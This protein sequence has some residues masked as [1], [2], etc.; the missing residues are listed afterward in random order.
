MV[1]VSDTGI[2]IDKDNVGKLFSKFSQLEAGMKKAGN[3]GS[4]L[5]LFIAKGIVE[6]SGGK[7]WVDSA[8]VG[9]GSTFYFTV[10][11]AANEGRISPAV[12]SEKKTGVEVAHHMIKSF[13]THK[14][15][16]A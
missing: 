13:S 16:R 8:G 14:V 2:G 10:G 12:H 15:G 3:K 4:G 11:L 7:I 6:A 5:G 9:L 1:S